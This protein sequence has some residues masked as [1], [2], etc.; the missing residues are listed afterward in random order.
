MSNKLF[1]F[2][3][4]ISIIIFIIGFSIS[5]SCKSSLITECEM[6]NNNGNFNFEH[7]L[8]NFNFENIF[9][10]NAKMVIYNC[11]IGLVS[12]GIYSVYNIFFNGFFFGGY[13]KFLVSKGYPYCLILKGILPHFLEF[14][15]IF[16][17]GGVGLF[18]I[19]LLIDLITG[20]K[21]I[22]IVFFKEFVKLI[23]I[24]LL[25]IGISAYMEVYVSLPLLLRSNL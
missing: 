21:T 19:I 12:G 7:K 11:L 24:I 23:A 1:L 17:S 8:N 14:I 5:F 22:D 10:N 4:L 25:L 3:V 6:K 16:I 9:S 2:F 18:G 13:L 20:E 15:A